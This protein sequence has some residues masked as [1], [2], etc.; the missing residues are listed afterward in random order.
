MKIALCH[1]S[2]LPRRGGCETYI[3]SLARRLV[4][5]GHA[6]HLYA[7]E[8]DPDAL[9]GRLR[10]LVARGDAATAAV[11]A[12]LPVVERALDR[13]AL[14]D[15]AADAEVGAEVGA[16]AVE[17]DDPAGGGGTVGDDPAVEQVA[18]DRPGAQVGGTAQ[19]IPRHRAGREPAGRGCLQHDDA[20]PPPPARGPML[21]LLLL[22]MLSPGVQRDKAPK[23]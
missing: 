2:V 11:G 20:L 13:I 23:E 14:G 7:C 3:A 4:L 1:T 9:P 16:S 18:G 22:L 8:W 10:R 5:D 21:L 12:V 6:V 17:D 15:D 19:Q